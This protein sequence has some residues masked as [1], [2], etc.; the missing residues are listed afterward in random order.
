L[1]EDDETLPSGDGAQQGFQFG[2]NG[3][4]VPSGGFNF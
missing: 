3:V 2:G 4:Q 1:E